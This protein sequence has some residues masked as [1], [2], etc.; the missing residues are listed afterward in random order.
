MVSCALALF[1]FSQKSHKAAVLL[2]IT[3]FFCAFAPRTDGTEA[4]VVFAA[5]EGRW[6]SPSGGFKVSPEARRL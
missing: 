5:P 3:L 2:G 4:A 6:N 1:D